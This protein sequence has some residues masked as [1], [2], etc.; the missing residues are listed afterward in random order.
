[1]AVRKTKEGKQHHLHLK[2]GD[3]GRYVFLPG[4][5]GRCETIAQYFD[6]PKFIAQ[7]R[8]Y[9]TYTGKLLGQKVSVTSTGI[10]CPS[11]AIAVE[12]LIAV[13]ADTFI[14][15]GTSGAIQPDT[16]TGEV[17]VVTGAIRDEGTSLHYMPIEFP[18]VADIDVVAALKEG[19]I[20]AKIPYRLGIT[21]S[22]D[23]FFGEMEPERMPLADK[24]LKRWKAWEVGGAVCSEMESSTLFILSSI[25][26][27]RAGGGDVNGRR[28]G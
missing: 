1:M 14:R 7:H 13:G 26:R 19:A 3:V 25:Y 21:Q 12:E 27:K 5:P 17:A 15:V 20:R 8:E 16:K 4:D 9:V 24:L 28:S 18:A 2:Q 6:E 22:K 10:G 23:S 11:T